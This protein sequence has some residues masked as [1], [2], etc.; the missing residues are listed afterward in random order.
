MNQRLLNCLLAVLLL[1]AVHAAHAQ[2]GDATVSTRIDASHITVGDAARVFLEIK[3]DPSRSTVQWAQLPDTFSK[4]EI[5]EK[6]KID[7]I[8]S[9]GLVTYKQRLSITGFDSGM[10]TIPSFTFNVIPKG[11]AAYAL[12]SDSLQLLVQTVAV[13]TTQAFKPIKGVMEVQLSW[14]DFIWLIV[15]ALVGLLLI[16]GLILYFLRRRGKQPAAIPEGPKESLQEKAQRLLAALDAE[17]LWQKG[18]VK[19][20]YVRLTD[21]VRG[22]VEAGFNT[23]AL[24]L[25]T[26]ELVDKAR[27]IPGLMQVA[28]LLETI[29]RTADLAKFAKA[30]PLPQEHVQ[31]MQLAYTLIAATT[32][33]ATQTPPTS[34]A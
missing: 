7:T 18:Q 31:S 27:V 8:P 26:D 34:P 4:L 23:A 20:Y 14:R 28:G 22:Y 12:S 9:G 17:Q 3:H 5:R 15:G 2:G 33:A 11:G 25:T 32:P 6:G 30:Q 21:I 16:I 1:F 19:E 29:L 10:F 24:E 13:D